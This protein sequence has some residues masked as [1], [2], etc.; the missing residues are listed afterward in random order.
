M[1]W[2]E[3]LISAEALGCIERNLRTAAPS[4]PLRDA[5]VASSF[6]KRLNDAAFL[7]LVADLVQQGWRVAVDCGRVGI[8][9]PSASA[10]EGEDAGAVKARI[11]A[12]LEAMRSEVLSDS[13][14][15]EFIRRA[16]ARRV[17]G[18]RRASI[19]ELIQDG[20]TL[21]RQLLELSAKP[22]GERRDALA[23]CIRPYV[24]VASPDELCRF[25][26]LTTSDVWRYFRL[27]WALPNRGT[28]GR[29]L[30]FMIRNGAAENH[31]VMGI[32]AL[33][34]PVAQ[35]K[36][37]EA[38]IGWTLD[39]VLARVASEP[40]WWPRQLQALRV[41]IARALSD[42][43]T[44]DLLPAD[45]EPDLAALVERAE[46]AADERRRALREDRLVGRSGRSKLPRK[47]DG[48]VDWRLASED[49]LF[50][51]KRAH[52]AAKLLFAE[53]L[54]RHA[55][56]DPVRARER[57]ARDTDFARAVSIALH[58]VR[59]AGLASRVLDLSICGAVPPFGGLLVGKLVA[60]AAASAEL[61]AAYR[62]RY[63]R[64]VS[65]IASQMAGREVI[66]AADYCAVTTTSLY[67]I[68]SSQYNRLAVGVNCDAQERH[69][70]WEDL[71]R[72]VGFGTVHLSSAT[73][74]CLAQA[75]VAARGY[76]HVNNR[77]GEGHSAALRRAREGLEVLQ[78]PP[79]LVLNHEAVRRVYGMTV[80][81]DAMTALLLGEPVDAAPPRFEHIAD[82]WRG[83]WL[84]QRVASDDVLSRVRAEGVATVRERLRD[85]RQLELRLESGD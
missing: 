75:T 19:L 71:G 48:S 66:R 72:S 5:A 74:R 12:S 49:A 50:V 33:A 8:E 11:R 31:P 36:R 55:P 29:T 58:E 22:S 44:D 42:L 53:R 56:M 4:P 28:P 41:T 17:V 84:C 30:Q 2:T 18:G 85:P 26:G 6:E 7:H 47:P 62:D 3:P 16:E 61:R 38:W 64:Q 77:F 35:L 32:G 46:L 81:E 39:A 60:L 82:A 51:K 21:A 54:L 27:T 40:D 70:R 34:S 37:R 79:D 57:I 76:R 23:T 14:T 15:Q 20:A 73:L 43:R 24:Q 13:K 63:S 59:K 45:T 83:R 25:T 67:G 80:S 1:R 78:V 52:L 10:G 68:A 65:E 9:P 69:I